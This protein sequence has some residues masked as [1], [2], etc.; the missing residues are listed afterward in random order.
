LSANSTFV[1]YD[2]IL[3][4][5]LQVKDLRYVGTRGNTRSPVCVIGEAPGQEEDRV[6]Y[7]FIGYS[8]QL[9]DKMI[10]EGGF[11]ASDVWFTNPYKTKPPDNDIKRIE[12]YGIQDNLF[13]DQFFEELR[14]FKPTILV[15][16]GKTAANILCPETKPKAYK[17][18]E[19]EKE[20]FMSWR[21]S[22]LISPFL[23][24]P[25]YVIPMAH[26][27]FVLRNYS[28]REICIFILT[29]ACEELTYWKQTTTLKP[30]PQRQLI[31]SPSFGGAY[32]FLRRCISSPEPI[33]VDIELLRRRVPYTIS[34]AV[35]MNEA[36]SLSFWNYPKNQCIELWR[37]M[38][39]IFSTKRQIGQNYTSF[40]C[41]W[42]R[43]MGFNVNLSLVE[44]TLILH[45]IL[46]P[47]FRHK[48]EF[49]GMQYTRQPFWK[50]EGKGWSQKDGLDQLMRYNALDAACTYEI[51][52]RMMEELRDRL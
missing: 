21:G 15:A 26:P 38:D 36:I 22:L 33:S 12:E 35:S 42:L 49:L 23:N 2:S 37:K 44:D 32:D 45:H 40:D 16:C 11:N 8:G 6:G 39:E 7:P 27:A 46:W 34:F 47:G 28:E 18:K 50:W 5:V 9:L 19:D 51:Y 31:T 25:H 24:W 17:G 52:L 43:A 30:L 14:Q 20:G 1:S 13:T 10:S 3:R 48:L 4:A 29:R 41:H